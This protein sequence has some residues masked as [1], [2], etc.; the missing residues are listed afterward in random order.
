VTGQITEV[1]RHVDGRAEEFECEGVLIRPG[2]LAVVRFVSPAPIGRYPKGTRTLGF[3]WR[4]RPYNL[5]RIWSPEGEH[6]D[7]RFDAVDDVRIEED[8]IEY[9]DLLLD[10]CVSS[11][12]DI[13]IE[14]EDQVAEAT[15]EGLLNVD[16]LDA[17]ERA[18]KTVSRDPRRIAREA[19]RLVPDLA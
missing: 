8:R 17:I 15:R 2:D 19:L 7:D 18:V 16:Q 13:T 10:I 4:R 9:L 12:G 5:Y 14:D 11:T 6:V 3:F 1:K